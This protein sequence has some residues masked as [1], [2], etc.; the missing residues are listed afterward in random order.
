MDIART[1]EGRKRIEDL[2]KAI[3]A[4]EN[5]ILSRVERQRL[6]DLI[7]DDIL[8]DRGRRA[9]GQA[10]TRAEKFQPQLASYEALCKEM[11]EKPANVALAWLLHNPVVTAPIIGPRTLDQLQGSLRAV[12]IKLSDEVL[13]QLDQIWP[14]PGGQAP[15]AYAW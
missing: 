5:I 14:G 1:G 2:L 15:E 7:L 9:S 4:E 10:Q 8:A 6:P 12:E 13:K 3:L 11:G